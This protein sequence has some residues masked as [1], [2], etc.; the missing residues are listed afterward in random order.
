M[1]S[2]VVRAA[3]SSLASASALRS[4]ASGPLTVWGRT[5][6]SNTQKCLWCLAELKLPHTLVLASAR[7]G[8]TSE[9]L[10]EG[11]PYGIVGT[12]EYAEL[13][14]HQ[15]VPTLRDGEA[16]IWESN[17]IVRYLAG[18]YGPQLYGGSQEGLAAASGWMDW[19][20]H[21][22]NFAPSFGSANHHLVDEVARTA[23]GARDESVV[24]AAHAEYLACLAR[25]E[26]HLERSGR[27]FVASDDFSIG[28]IPLA[29]ELNRWSLCVHRARADGVDLACPALPRLDDYYRRML[30]RPAYEEQVFAH[31]RA[32]QA[33]ADSDAL[34][35]LPS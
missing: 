6:S 17:T 10:G 30:E 26:A 27:P 3:L 22:S 33:L 9:L 7:L 15:M 28:D 24:A 16:V 25:A 11:E 20:L 12:P 35:R 29:V 19:A 14:P 34:R 23:P 8:P 1:T 31:E 18:K 13:C 4:D 21:G 2:L 5:S 32:H